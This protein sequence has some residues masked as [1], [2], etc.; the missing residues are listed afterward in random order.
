MKNIFAHF[1]TCNR[2]E[3]E[4]I[5]AELLRMYNT[6][7]LQEC[8]LFA[9]GDVVAYAEQVGKLAMIQGVFDVLGVEFVPGVIIA[10][11]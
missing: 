3:R 8:E 7:I 5:A 6:A 9:D 2:K 4:D 1:E 10:T 11:E